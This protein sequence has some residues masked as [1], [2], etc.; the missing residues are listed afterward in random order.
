MKYSITA[1][2]EVQALG[3]GTRRRTC[4][5]GGKAKTFVFSSRPTLLDELPPELAV[6]PYLVVERIGP[7]ADPPAPPAPEPVAPQKAP[8]AASRP[9]RSS[10]SS[11]GRKSR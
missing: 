6:D 2:R 7:P 11:R 5:L 1:A 8:K 4:W 3:D 9:V 10:K